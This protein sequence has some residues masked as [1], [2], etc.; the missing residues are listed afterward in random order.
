MFLPFP[1]ILLLRNSG[2]S[3]H[4][5]AIKQMQIVCRWN[6]KYVTL[7]ICTE[8]QQNLVPNSRINRNEPTSVSQ[9][10]PVYILK[11]FSFFLPTHE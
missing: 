7:I 2:D 9:L 1:F 4:E 8:V 5:L 10:T 6:Y 11:P 3:R